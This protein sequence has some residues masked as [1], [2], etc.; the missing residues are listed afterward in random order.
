MSPESQICKRCC[1]SGC[2]F[3]LAAVSGSPY[4]SHDGIG[5][6][7]KLELVAM[8]L[9]SAAELEGTADYEAPHCSG[10]KWGYDRSQ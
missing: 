3:T 2:C 7:A 1:R 8:G 9:M 5:A 6:Y 10:G 4:T